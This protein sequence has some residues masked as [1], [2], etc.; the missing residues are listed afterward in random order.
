VT[1]CC[2]EGDGAGEEA[3]EVVHFGEEWAIE[4]LREFTEDC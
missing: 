1:A 3:D 4:P 2:G